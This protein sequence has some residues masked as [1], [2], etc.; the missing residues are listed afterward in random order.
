MRKSQLENQIPL[1][2][3]KGSYDQDISL[4]LKKDWEMFLPLEENKLVSKFYPSRKAWF[5]N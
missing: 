2:F 3:E 5:Q 4:A 1:W